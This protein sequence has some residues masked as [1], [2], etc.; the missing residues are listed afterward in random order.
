MLEI[1]LD[2]VKNKEPNELILESMFWACTAY[3]IIGCGKEIVNHYKEKRA[4]EKNLPKQE[5]FKF[6]YD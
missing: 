2:Y 1:I 3:V 5:E 6:R 4:Y